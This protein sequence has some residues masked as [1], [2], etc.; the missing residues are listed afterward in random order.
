MLWGSA[1]TLSILGSTSSIDNSGR[2][3]ACAHKCA[4]KA[5]KGAQTTAVQR[6]CRLR[7][8]RCLPLPHLAID[9]LSRL[10]LRI[11][12]REAQSQPPCP[13]QLSSACIADLGLSSCFGGR[14][15]G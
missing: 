13:R 7:A 11:A 2:A 14:P 5:P 6:A 8:T 4:G 1:Q 10:A 3:G 9:L 15:R 12:E